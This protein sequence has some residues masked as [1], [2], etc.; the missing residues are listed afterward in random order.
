VVGRSVSAEF[1]F[2]WHGEIVPQDQCTRMVNLEHYAL[3]GAALTIAGETSPL[4]SST[5]PEYVTRILKRTMA[6]HLMQGGAEG[7]F[8]VADSDVK[9][10]S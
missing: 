4:R 9:A 8:L 10:D 6:R 5:P 2:S 3:T 1:F 7:E